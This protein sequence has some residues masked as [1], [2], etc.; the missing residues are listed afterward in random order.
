[1]RSQTHVTNV[2]SFLRGSLLFQLENSTFLFTINCDHF[3]LSYKSN[4]LLPH[5]D[6]YSSILTLQKQKV[7]KE[8]NNFSIRAKIIEREGKVGEK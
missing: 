6:I 8:K 5:N 4:I 2:V 3:P 7:S 1:M